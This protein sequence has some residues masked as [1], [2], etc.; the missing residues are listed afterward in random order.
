MRH[1]AHALPLEDEAIA[2]AIDAMLVPTPRSP[3]T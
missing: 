2:D 1:D 3:A